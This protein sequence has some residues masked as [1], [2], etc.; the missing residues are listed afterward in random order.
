MVEVD[1]P[2][3]LIRVPT[4][5]SSSSSPSFSVRPDGRTALKTRLLVA[6]G[7]TVVRV[8]AAEWEGAGASAAREAWLL[9]RLVEAGA[10]DG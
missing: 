6:A 5:S 9:A 8:G 3:H 7:W 1:G 4:A 2:T 10:L